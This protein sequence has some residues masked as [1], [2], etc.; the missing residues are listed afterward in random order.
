M[1]PCSQLV[2]WAS[3][4]Q[5]CDQP[6]LFALRLEVDMDHDRGMVFYPVASDLLPAKPFYGVSISHTDGFGALYCCAAGRIQSCVHMVWKCI[7]ITTIFYIAQ[8]KG[9]KKKTLQVLIS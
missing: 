7:F 9:N 1:P 6:W 2:E 4:G 5:G 3:L 8:K